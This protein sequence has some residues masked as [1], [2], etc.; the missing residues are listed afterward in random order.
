VTAFDTRHRIPWTGRTWNPGIFGCTPISPACDSCY[1][2][3]TAHRGLGPY[4][5]HPDITKLTEHG[6]TWTGI[7]R[8]VIERVELTADRLPRRR[9]DLVFTTSMGDLWHPAVPRAFSVAVHV[10]MVVRPWLTFQTLTKHPGRMRAAF[11]DPAFIE[12]VAEGAEAHRLG[13]HA[14]AWPAPN[15]WPGATVEDG[16][17][18][19][20]RRLRDLSRVPVAPGAIRF[21]SAEP[22]IEAIR[23]D[24]EDGAI[25][26][27]VLGGEAKRT[28]LEPR[29]F[30]LDAVRRVAD[31]AAERGA[32]VQ[33]KQLGTLWARANGSATEDGTDPA[34]WPGDLAAL[35]G[36]PVEVA[37]LARL[38]A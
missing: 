37:R 3:C 12:A 17:V 24:V 32:A 35:H 14:V 21:V 22:M 28:R 15:I 16:H 31:T 4:A 9:P 13:G 33:V 26:H 29:P 30:D 18:N 1:A 27:V 2:A 19:R 25:G 11:T 34:E 23:L 10:A 38:V 5:D 8:T 36:V 6:V 20:L 7:V